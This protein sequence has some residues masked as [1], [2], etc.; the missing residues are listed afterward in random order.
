[1]NHHPSTSSTT[2]ST[3]HILPLMIFLAATACCL[4]ILY[5]NRNS[6]HE[7]DSCLVQ[8]DCPVEYGIDRP[9]EQTLYPE[10]KV[11]HKTDLE[12]YLETYCYIMGQIIKSSLLLLGVVLALHYIV[13]LETIKRLSQITVAWVMFSRLMIGGEHSLSMKA[14][15]Y[16][17]IGAGILFMDTCAHERLMTMILALACEWARIPDWTWWRQLSQPQAQQVVATVDTATAKHLQ[18]SELSLSG[19]SMSLLGL[20][21]RSESSDIALRDS[22]SWRPNI[23]DVIQFQ[24]IGFRDEMIHEILK[25]PVWDFLVPY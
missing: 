22:S 5:H 20:K 18:V 9:E 19:T 2:F 21:S 23:G 15:I 3:E 24:T 7:H 13:G 6:P 12:A 4:F 25:N 14:R 11:R 10:D 8:H 16:I 17:A 1:M